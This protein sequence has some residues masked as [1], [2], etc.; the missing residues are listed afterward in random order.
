LRR[1]KNRRVV[2]R[3]STRWDFGSIATA[4]EIICVGAAA[5]KPTT[6][7]AA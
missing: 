7:I 5:I 1:R 2:V 6:G 4:V 3:P